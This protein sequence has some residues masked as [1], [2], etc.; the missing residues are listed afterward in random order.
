M[1]SVVSTLAPRACANRHDEGVGGVAQREE[2]YTKKHE[3]EA[4]VERAQRECRPPAR[5]TPDLANLLQPH[6]QH[7]HRQ[8]DGNH[9]QP[10]EGGEGALGEQ[11]RLLLGQ[12]DHADGH[13]QPQK[14]AQCVPCPLKA[15]GISPP[16]WFDAV[17]DQRVPRR[18]ADAFAEAVGKPR[19]KDCFPTA[20]HGQQRLGCQRKRIAD[21]RGPLA[22]ADA[23]RDV[24]GN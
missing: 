8:R 7:H 18:V 16:R 12:I 14:R 17:S 4:P 3:A 6:D 21:H 5:F 15:K 2:R 11:G 22:V 23:V 24:A 19:H 9:G 20:C 13:R 1:N 10:D